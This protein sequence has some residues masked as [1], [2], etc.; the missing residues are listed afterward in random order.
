MANGVL[1]TWIHG[2]TAGTLCTTRAHGSA[3]ATMYTQLAAH[4]IERGTTY[5]TCVHCTK[6]DTAYTLHRPQLVRTSI[7]AAQLM[8]SVPTAVPP[9][10]HLSGAGTICDTMHTTCAQGTGVDHSCGS[11]SGRGI[12]W[13]IVVPAELVSVQTTY[14]KLSGNLEGISSEG[15]SRE[16]RGNLDGISMESRENLDGISMESRW[17]LKGISRESRGNIE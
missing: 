17:N 16:S 4:S 8:H 6:L 13:C 2:I 12:A 14:S 15:I 11:L 9:T 1:Q 7:P 10:P 3:R 5:S